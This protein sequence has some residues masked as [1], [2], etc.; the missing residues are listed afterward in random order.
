MQQMAARLLEIFTY[1][2]E[3]KLLKGVFNFKSV[4][5]FDQA[6]PVILEDTMINYVKQIFIDLNIQHIQ[7]PWIYLFY[8]NTFSE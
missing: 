1:K 7:I 3:K 8:N 4:A 6:L 2:Y 5:L